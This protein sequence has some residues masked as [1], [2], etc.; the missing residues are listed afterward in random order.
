MHVLVSD[1]HHIV[2]MGLEIVLNKIFD[3]VLVFSVQ[4]NDELEALI[5]SEK[6][7]DLFFLDIE[8]GFSDVSEQIKSIKLLPYKKKI[9]VYSMHPESIYGKLVQR[10]GGDGYISKKA[11]T[12]ELTQ[13]IKF[14]MQ[15]LKYFKDD[16]TNST[17]SNPLSKLSKRELQIAQ[18][19][20]KGAGVKEITDN[21]G[22]KLSTISTYKKRVF[23]KL[24]VKNVIE[25]ADIAKKYLIS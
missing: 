16:Q 11:D 2:Q 8:M 7:F 15:G 18:L 10:S 1:D 25:L 5:N 4:T 19:I 9:I 6:K 23:E 20:V 14:V 3:K 13:G 21:T 12:Q 17:E 22:L 24:G